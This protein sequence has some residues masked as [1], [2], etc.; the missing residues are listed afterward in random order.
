MQVPVSSWQAENL[1][2]IKQKKKIIIKVERNVNVRPT[3]LN[4]EYKYLKNKIK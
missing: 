1:V 4:N 2:R 3:V